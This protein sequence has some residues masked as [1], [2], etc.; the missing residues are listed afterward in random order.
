MIMSNS[1]SGLSSACRNTARPARSVT[2]VRSSAA[3][4]ISNPRIMI[5]VSLPNPRNASSRGSRPVKASARMRPRAMTSEE[6]RSHQKSATA[7]ASRTSK[8]RI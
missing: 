8:S 2:P 6:I 4:R 1:R 7:T 5:T 3:V